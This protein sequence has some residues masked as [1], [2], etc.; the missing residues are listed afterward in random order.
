MSNSGQV[1]FMRRAEVHHVTGLKN[2]AL[3]RRI[4]SGTFPPPI[5][6]G[7]KV[8][9]WIESEVDAVVKALIRG[10]DD[11]GLRLLVADLLAKREQIAAE[12]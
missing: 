2:T 9:G 4:N 7:P 6:L 5:P 3:Q 11:A 12:A 1:R 10:R 8:V